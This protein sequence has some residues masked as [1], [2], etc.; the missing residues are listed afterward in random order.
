GGDQSFSAVPAS[1]FVNGGALAL[2]DSVIPGSEGGGLRITGSA[3]GLAPNTVRDNA[4]TAV[5]LAVPAHPPID[6]PPPPNNGVAALVLDGGTLTGD[7]VWDDPEV[8]YL[9]GGTVTVP[10]GR[11]LTL[12]AGQIVKG[13]GYL[14]KLMVQGKLTAPGTADRPVILTDINDDS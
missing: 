14:T 3:P 8:V 4:R 2:T 12:A 9:L 1:V 7:R 11:T 10:Q 6:R 13:R 5:R